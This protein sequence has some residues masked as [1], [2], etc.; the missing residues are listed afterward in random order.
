M[1]GSAASA[2]DTKAF[3]FGINNRPKHLLQMMNLLNETD[4]IA[5]KCVNGSRVMPDYW[6]SIE[7][8]DSPTKSK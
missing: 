7:K 5:E 8:N 6:M 2:S 4:A 3:G 1:D